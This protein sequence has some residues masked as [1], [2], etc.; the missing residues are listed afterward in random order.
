[1]PNIDTTA[2]AMTATAAKIFGQTSGG[3][4]GFVLAETLASMPPSGLELTTDTSLTEAQ[5][6]ANG[7]ITN[8]G[9]SGEIDVTLPAVSYRI[10]RTIIVEEPQIIEVNPP[11]GEAFD[12]GGTTLDADDVIDSPAVVGSKAVFS[13]MKNASGTWHW[14]VDA[15]RGSWVDSGASD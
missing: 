8:Q 1:M 2:S 10:T 15:V 7:Y 6:L 3:T 9:A 13:R 11:S 12:L 14:S 5:L 4:T